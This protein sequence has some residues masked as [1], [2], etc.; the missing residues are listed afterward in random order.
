MLIV[1]V[2]FGP[3]DIE[4]ARPVLAMIGLSSSSNTVPDERC[5][6]LDALLKLSSSSSQSV[7]SSESGEK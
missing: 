2:T 5:R 7:T 4:T 1:L 6:D 3:A